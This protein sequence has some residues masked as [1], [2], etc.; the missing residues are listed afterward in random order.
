M[1][2]SIAP[3]E[4]LRAGLHSFA[5]EFVDVTQSLSWESFREDQ[6]PPY[7]S[8]STGLAGCAYG[9]W[10]LASSLGRAD[11]LDSARRIT[12][13]ARQHV[14]DPLAFTGED[15][16][17]KLPRESLYAGVLGVALCE[18][19]LAD[20]PAIEAFL[21]KYSSPP[22]ET[23]LER[24]E[25]HLGY[26]GH[27]LALCIL[28]RHVQIHHEA[29]Y[30]RVAKA[31]DECAARLAEGFDALTSRN[32]EHER[33]P[34][35]AHGIGGILLALVQWH[36]CA[37]RALPSS[38]VDQVVDAAAA[39]F[40]GPIRADGF[41]ASYC[42]GAPGLLLLSTETYRHADDPRL[43]DLATK[44]AEFSFER[45]TQNPTLCCGL[46]GLSVALYRFGAATGREEWVAKG[47]TCLEEAFASSISPPWFYGLLQGY[48][49]LACVAADV[50][51]GRVPEFPSVT[52]P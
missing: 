37:E 51:T 13:L 19:I 32:A 22:E 28:S 40:Q 16:R 12:L 52:I 47:E 30:V 42:N 36:R 39:Y 14:E 35:V 17:P 2:E 44:L 48:A 10:R 33:K 6:A 8:P 34:A 1:D 4:E 9:L 11:S 50:A 5:D 31:R 20:A 15:F 49:G 43:R 18:A 26:A 46:G 29:A 27:L 41:E 38:L 3:N 23:T 25:L 24:L 21:A 45:R 7:V